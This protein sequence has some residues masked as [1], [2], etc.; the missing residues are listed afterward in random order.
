VKANDQE[1]SGGRGDAAV[2]STVLQ[3]T[4][5]QHL[6]IEVVD[7]RGQLIPWIQSGSDNENAR[8]ILTLTKLPDTTQ[9]KELRYYT[10]TRATVSLPFE[11]KD[12]PMP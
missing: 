9:P 1:G 3:R 8:V 11:F 2:F 6:Q 7:M 12:L 4:D 5:P 10:L